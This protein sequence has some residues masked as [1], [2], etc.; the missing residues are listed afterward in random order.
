VS[1]TPPRHFA[2][3]N[4]STLVTDRDV[5]FWAEAC[6]RQLAEDVCPA[7]G[8]DE[9]PGVAFYE[10]DV[11]FPGETAIVAAFVDD[12]HDPGVSGEHGIAGKLPFVLVDAHASENPPETLGHE[13]GEGTVNLRLD[14]WT[15]PI[16]RGGHSYRYPIEIDDPT[17]GQPYTKSVTIFGETRLV[18]V[19]NFVY[20]A[21]FDPSNATGPWDHLRQLSG[22][23]QIGPAGYAAPEK[24]GRIV[25]IGPGE[26]LVLKARKFSAWSRTSRLVRGRAIGR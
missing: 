14:R 12:L 26:E 13:L 16:L 19:P 5:A 7:W 24:D 18:D 17:E 4:R 2:V 20:P 10:P 6:A 23:L 3:V 22:P 15:T 8:I 1:Y 25:F 11:R 21:W 9:P